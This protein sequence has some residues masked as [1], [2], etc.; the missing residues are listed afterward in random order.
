MVIAAVVLIRV[1]LNMPRSYWPAYLATLQI[2]LLI[3]KQCLVKPG[4]LV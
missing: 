4:H 1:V 2:C 3:S